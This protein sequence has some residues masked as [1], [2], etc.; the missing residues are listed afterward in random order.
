MIDP[1]EKALTDLCEGRPLSIV[2]PDDKTVPSFVFDLVTRTQ[3]IFDKLSTKDTPTRHRQRRAVLTG[4]WLER[5]VETALIARGFKQNVDLARKHRIK[6]GTFDAELDFCF[7]KT[8]NFRDVKAFF[9]CKW[10]LRERY[11]EALLYACKF[12]EEGAKP[13]GYI[14]TSGEP[15]VKTADVSLSKHRKCASFGVDLVLVDNSRDWPGKNTFARKGVMIHDLFDV[16]QELRSI[17][18]LGTPEKRAVS[19]RQRT[20]ERRLDNF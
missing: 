9:D 17:L 1:F 6:I 5:A 15:G 11:Y 8:S 12:R 2:V 4:D 13:N 18:K 20:V 3:Q 14:V 16:I 10:T 7:P 19:T